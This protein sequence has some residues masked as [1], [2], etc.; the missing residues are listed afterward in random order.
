MIWFSRVLS[1]K[2]KI[3]EKLKLHKQKLLNKIVNFLFFS[4]ICNVLLE[5]LSMQLFSLSNRKRF[6]LFSALGLTAF[7]SLQAQSCLDCNQ[8]TGG[9]GFASSWSNIELTAKGLTDTD[10]S[11]QRVLYTGNS[12]LSPGVGVSGPTGSDAR[13]KQINFVP[14]V[15]TEVL[16]AKFCR[17]GG[18]YGADVLLSHLYREY[19]K[20]EKGSWRALDANLQEVAF[21]N[22]A[23]T[24]NLG[25]NNPGHL[26]V[27]I[28]T[29]VPFYYLEFSA[30]EYGNQRASIPDASDYFLKEITP[31]CR[32][33]INCGQIVGGDQKPQSWTSVA[34]SA[35]PLGSTTFSNTNVNFNVSLGWGGP[36]SGGLG[37]KSPAESETNTA[38][39][40]EINYYRELNDTE[41]L[42]VDFG[43]GSITNG[44]NA[45]DVLLSK[46]YNYEH[47]TKV[48]VGSWKA[49]DENLQEVGAGFFQATAQWS[50]SNPGH[51]ELKIFTAR[52][53]RY[54][55]F[56]AGAY[57]T[58][59]ARRLADDS[60][61]LVRKITALCKPVAVC[62]NTLGGANQDWSKAGIS[63]K[64]LNSVHFLP[65][66]TASFR[67]DWQ[68]VPNSGGVGVPGPVNE[69]GDRSRFHEINYIAS[70]NKSEAVR[71]NLGNLFTSAKVTVSRFYGR[72]GSNNAE[73][74]TWIAYKSTL[75]GLTEVG[76][77][78][79][80]AVEPYC[81]SC[82]GNF[83]FEINTQQEFQILEFNAMPY[84]SASRVESVPA[85][86]S[87]YLLH[88]IVLCPDNTPFCSDLI[89]VTASQVISFTQGKAKDGSSVDAGSSDA[90]K[91]LG[92]PQASDETNKLAPDANF[93]SLGFG[94][95]I[96]LQL[97]CRLLDKTGYDFEL[98]ETSYG[99]PTFRQYPE[100]AEVYV[101]KD[102]INW[103]SLGLTQPDKQRPQNSNSTNDQLGARFDISS[104]NLPFVKY[105][106]VVDRSLKESAAFNKLADGF[107]LD[108][109][110]CIQKVKLP[111]P[112]GSDD[113]LPLLNVQPTITENELVITFAKDRELS[114]PETTDIVVYNTSGQEVL[115]Y[116]NQQVV[117]EKITLELQTL[118]QGMY[119]I[120][121]MSP[122]GKRIA[123]F[124]KQ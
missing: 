61:Y 5:T 44:I 15:G 31:I 63:V 1:N 27:E 36:N 46:F 35:K 65:A 3:F 108:G 34:L 24:Q 113:E 72:E 16:R 92:F 68:G 124:F 22:F 75:T 90:T 78:E 121:S 6:L 17:Q 38:Y 9:N 118:K 107:D 105:I 71:V 40:E 47:T 2:L 50:S 33:S 66:T 102:G 104:A 54:L 82:A 94:G 95:E 67:N 43:A 55:E 85:D 112:K 45:A 96:V 59:Q 53:F 77:G 42:R 73:R 51:Y 100:V 57:Q 37:V 98:L 12:V 49:L 83:T 14:G 60:D 74:G 86:D 109:I 123:K 84:T 80:K 119:I 25:N 87:D 8:K 106:K 103:V 32:T 115:R 7:S 23:S 69:N 116:R 122:T 120:H 30:V 88:S 81:S 28:R 18:F 19:G 41:V 62:E 4:Y 48:E 58:A 26:T 117:D 11:S 101:S 52:P 20:V 79:F 10:F 70:E 29:N 56:S 64:P 39:A 76:R 21:G 114:V 13:F 99:N 111:D 110:S 93:V 91:A 89:C 97:S